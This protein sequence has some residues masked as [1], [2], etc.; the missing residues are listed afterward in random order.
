MGDGLTVPSVAT[1]ALRGARPGVFWVDKDPAD[2][3]REPLGASST[4]DLV[5]VGGGFTG[6]WAAIAAA[7]RDP[8]RRIVVL[9]GE[10]VGFGASSRNGGFVDS[11]LTHGLG[12]GVAH[13]PGEIADLV[14]LGREN[15][16]GLVA[17]ID[18]LGIACDLERTGELTLADAPW[19]AEE[20]AA[21]VALHEAH[22]IPADHLDADGVA[23]HLRSPRFVGGMRRPDDVVLVDPARLVRGL[24]DAAE[25]LGV[26]VHDH[27]AVTGID[28]D[29][30]TLTVR[31][32]GG[33]LTAAKVLVATNAYRGPVRRT[34]RWIVPVYDHVM[35]TEP[36]TADQLRDLG[37]SGREGASDAANRFHY[38]RITADDRV[39]WG[40]FEPT[41]HW[42]NGL[43]PAFDQDDHMHH[44]LA[45]N[46]FVT[47]PQLEGVRFSHRWG[48]PIGTTSRFSATW[49]TGHDGRLAWVGGYT[50]LGVAAS[51]FGAA[52]ALDLVDGLDTERTALEMVRKPPVPFPP[53]PLRSLGIA[54]TKRAVRRADEHGGRQGP[55]LRTLDRF[56]VGFDF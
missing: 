51:R 7:E 32:A 22:G 39:L 12:N 20:L 19:Q 55:W 15:L 13:W 40:G 56:G 8:G 35:V 14:R 11:S 18:R 28:A 6:L 30:S 16:A 37:W 50:G 54:L 23:E 47:F 21:S 38:F 10:V 48:G 33:S 17:D 1:E 25:R 3:P 5:V 44:L 4:A 45:A 52:T 27:S 24:R 9:E 36:L 43:D 31:T 29:G 46:F 2:T 26:T 53:E 49:G 34:R 41:Y 42:R